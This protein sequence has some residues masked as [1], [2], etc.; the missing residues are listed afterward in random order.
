MT[1]DDLVVLGAGVVLMGSI[2]WWFFRAGRTPV[3][4]ATTSRGV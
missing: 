2:Y 4:A 1:T 3:Q